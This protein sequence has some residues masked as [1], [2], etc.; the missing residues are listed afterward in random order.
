MAKI[1]IDSGY[2]ED[3]KTIKLRILLGKGSEVLPL[4]LLCAQT[5]Y[6]CEAVNGIS[7]SEIEVLAGWWGENGKMAK[8]M[9]SA[10]FL[11]CE[12]TGE[13]T[14]YFFDEKTK[15]TNDDEKVT[16][17]LSTEKEKE[18]EKEKK[19][20]PPCIPLKEKKIEL[21]EK[22]KEI[23]LILTEIKPTLS[24]FDVFWSE[25]PRKVGK[26]YARRCWNKL[27][28]DLNTCLSAL[29]WQKSSKQ[30]QS[31]SQFIPHASTWLNQQRWLDEPDNNTSGKYSDWGEK[32]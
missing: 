1:T 17:F 5:K 13:N 2:F 7:S 26:E 31:G 20:N 28:P 21:K 22:E 8:A 29:S 30:W 9:V 15:N 4:R 11:T 14:L 24:D 3:I 10:G 25:Y 16:S 6:G 19:K 18:K 27:H 32:I 23:S 12:N